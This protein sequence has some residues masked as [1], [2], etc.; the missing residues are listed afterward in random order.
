MMALEL[1][2]SETQVR[3]VKLAGILHDIGKVNVPQSILCKPGS[4]DDD[5]WEIVKQHPELGAQIL[6]HPDLDDVRGWVG[7]HHERPDGNGYPSGLAGR[8]LA[9]E[10]RILAVADAFEAMTSDRSYRLSIGFEAAREELRRCAGSQF[11][12]RVVDALLGVLD[13][14]P[15]RARALAA[16]A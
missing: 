7:A 13:R 3:R 14:E 2:L 1:G 12:P 11:D 9:L 15:Q 5:E 4:L 6:E 16:V 8:D 10:A